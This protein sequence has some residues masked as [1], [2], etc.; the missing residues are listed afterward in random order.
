MCNLLPNL[1]HNAAAVVKG[2]LCACKLIMPPRVNGR[3]WYAAYDTVK[4]KYSMTTL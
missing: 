2:V 3:H 1:I 4:A